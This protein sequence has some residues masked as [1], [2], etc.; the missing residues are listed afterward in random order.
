MVKQSR[1]PLLPSFSL[2]LLAPCS[3]PGTLVSRSVSG[4]RNSFIDRRE[5]DKAALNPVWPKRVCEGGSVV[6]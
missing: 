2:L 4:R 3:I 5:E 1:E 6:A